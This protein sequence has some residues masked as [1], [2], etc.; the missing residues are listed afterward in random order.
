MTIMSSRKKKSSKCLR[1]D[2]S[3][4]SGPTVH[5]HQTRNGLSGSQEAILMDGKQGEKA[6]VMITQELDWKSEAMVSNLMK[7]NVGSNHRQYVQRKSGG[8]HGLGLYF[9][10]S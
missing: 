3:D 4:A 1:Q 7:P 2:P 9:P 5:W 8:S 6:E 10:F